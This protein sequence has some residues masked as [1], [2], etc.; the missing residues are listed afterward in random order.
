MIPFIIYN[1]SCHS[2]FVGDSSDYSENKVEVNDDDSDIDLDETLE[3]GKL[4]LLQVY[5]LHLNS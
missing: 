1:I 2:F 4:T 5:V 3:I